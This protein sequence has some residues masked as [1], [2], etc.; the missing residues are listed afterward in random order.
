MRGVI[1]GLFV[2][3]MLCLTADKNWAKRFVHT[4]ILLVGL[5]VVHWI[6]GTYFGSFELV[7]VLS[8]VSGLS[9][10]GLYARFRNWSLGRL[11]NLDKDEG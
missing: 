8:Y 1:I 3:V 4:P 6:Y 9:V 2:G 11:T 7:P 5:I 10:V